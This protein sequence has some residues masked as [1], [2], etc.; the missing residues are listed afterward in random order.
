MIGTTA[1]SG[2][3]LH[4]PLECS[5]QAD[6]PGEPW[7]IVPGKFAQ[8]PVEEPVVSNGF[9]MPLEHGEVLEPLTTKQCV[10]PITWET[11]Q[12]SSSDYLNEV[13]SIHHCSRHCIRQLPEY[14][15]KKKT[16]YVRAQAKEDREDTKKP[17]SALL[18]Y[19]N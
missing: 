7:S 9:H 2:Y 14:G 12:Y 19:S 13:C 10:Q 4:S 1:A 3:P 18:M 11:P 6:G 15:R 16:G 5:T 17:T 8:T